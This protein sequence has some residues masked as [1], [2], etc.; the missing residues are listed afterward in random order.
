[1]ST[2]TTTDTTRYAAHSYLADYEL[3]HSNHPSASDSRP[4]SHPDAQLAQRNPPQWPSNYR[5]IPP[6]RPINRDLDQSQRRVYTTTGERIFLFV[7]FTGVQ[8]NADINRLW[9]ATGGR[10]AQSVFQYKI[11]GEW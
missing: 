9:N 2:T 1:M 5:R 4:N 3:H 8:V 11:G 6:Y 7:M 10:L